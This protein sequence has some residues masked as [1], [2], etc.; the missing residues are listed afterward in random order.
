MLDQFAQSL[1]ELEKGGD[2]TALVQRLLRLAHTL[3]GAARVVKLPEIAEH[4]H[5]IE[6]VLAPLRDVSDPVPADR[7]NAVLRHVDAVDARVRGLGSPESAE[8]PKSAE[9]IAAP[10][11]VVEDAIRTVR[12]DIADMD[13]LIDGS[14]RD[15]CASDSAARCGRRGRAGT[16]SGRSSGPAAGAGR[17]RRGGRVAVRRA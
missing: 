7:V 6:D 2:S 5:A 11:Q 1:L 4:A 13:T 15:P 10:A 17:R 16:P 8:K 14:L 9:K 12:T 3:K